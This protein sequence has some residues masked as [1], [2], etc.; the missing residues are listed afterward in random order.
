MSARL[1]YRLVPL[2]VCVTL[3]FAAYHV[4]GAVLAARAHNWPFVVF[5][6]L[7]SLAGVALAR[8]LWSARRT[9]DRQ[10]KEAAAAGVGR[11][12]ALGCQLSALGA[13]PN[14][15]GRRCRSAR[16]SHDRRRLRD[17]RRLG[18]R[19]ATPRWRAVHR[20]ASYRVG[21]TRVART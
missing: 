2:L 7:F 5:Y 17:L 18:D 16:G 20:G 21:T 8:A 12:S 4:Y 19:P 1:L 3:V 10:M 9:I 6:A 13:R 15:G 14:A 11:L